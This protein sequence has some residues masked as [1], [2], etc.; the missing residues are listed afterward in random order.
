MYLPFLVAIVVHTVCLDRQAEHLIPRW[1]G[2]GR[3]LPLTP[4]DLLH[5]PGSL[6]CPNNR[7]GQR[8]TQ[9]HVLLLFWKP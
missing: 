4:V 6:C 7:L 1:P 2:G 3:H 8:F 5:S 9:S